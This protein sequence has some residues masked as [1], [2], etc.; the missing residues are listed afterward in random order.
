LT[1]VSFGRSSI[2]F[3]RLVLVRNRKG[4]QA[5]T[6]R[7]QAREIDQTLTGF[8]YRTALSLAGLESALA[9]G[10]LIGVLAIVPVAGVATGFALFTWARR[11]AICPWTKV[12]VG[13]RPRIDL[14]SGIRRTYEWY[15]ASLEMQTA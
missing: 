2:P 15:R 11:I 4:R 14:G 9:L 5:D 10:L 1:A 13:W 8:I 12:A 7:R 3:L 6:I